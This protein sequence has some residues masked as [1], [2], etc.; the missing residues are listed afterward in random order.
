MS[1]WPAYPCFRQQ[2]R[3]RGQ[4]VAEGERKYDSPPTKTCSRCHTDKPLDEFYDN[5]KKRNGVQN[6]C[7]ACFNAYTTARFIHR[8]VE[9]IEYLGG[10]C[11]HCGLALADS[12]PGVFEFHHLDPGTKKASFNEIRR[13][14]WPRAKRELDKTILLCANCHRAEHAEDP[15]RFSDDYDFSGW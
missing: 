3:T 5:P 4:W 6:Y 13:W 1:V 15:S 10:S 14:S 11:R 9:A 7:K 2:L 8:K 12:V